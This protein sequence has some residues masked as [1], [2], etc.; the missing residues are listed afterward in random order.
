[1]P[2]SLRR[3]HP[4]IFPEGS[5]FLKVDQNTDLAALFIVNELDSAHG[6]ILLQVAASAQES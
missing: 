2:F 5:V 3:D 6:S 4:E 1:M